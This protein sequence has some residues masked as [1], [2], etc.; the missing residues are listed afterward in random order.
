MIFG[1]QSAPLVTPGKK[2]D[3]DDVARVKQFMKENDPRKLRRGDIKNVTITERDLNLFLDYALAQ[4]PAEK[5]LFVQAQLRQDLAN[6]SF[7]YSLPENPF[8]T[9]LNISAILFPSAD[10]IKIRQLKI[11]G[12][13]IPGWLVNPTV[14]L[15][16]HILKQFNL[17]RNFAEAY[18]AIQSIRIFEGS[19][20]IVYQWQPD[21]IKNLQAQGRDFLLSSDEKE[22]LIVYN[23]Q[24]AV[25][26][27]T[28]NG[29]QVSLN[30]CL[31]PLFRFAEQRTL[32]KGDA[33][34]ENRALI[35]TLA[36]Y[37]VGRN[38][39]KFIGDE[40]SKPQPQFGRVRITLAGR[41]DLSKHFLVSA[42]ITVSGGTGLANLAG[43]FKE[44]DDS[45]GGSGFSFSDLAADRAGVKFAEA[46]IASSSQ[47]KLVQ[48]QMGNIAMES[49]FM[50]NIENL[51]EGIQELEFKQTY[52]D[53]DSA[54]YRMI[55]AEIERRINLCRIYSVG[56]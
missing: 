44:M 3:F 8:G 1:I 32:T 12:L 23:N 5:D 38:V 13:K 6:F 10:Q 24:L 43:I 50:P 47:A 30:Q 34:A 22:R 15:G 18:H 33:E 26:T 48:Q 36:A 49:D 40:K 14:K 29:R 16:H 20:T 52:Q 55:E 21:V 4:A 39:G 46:A 54:T 7:S 31:Q 53:L 9:Y 25:V 35:L 37:S 17:Y 42:A 56:K 2:L 41:T 45:R 19:V 11:G 51:P 28:L 27:Q